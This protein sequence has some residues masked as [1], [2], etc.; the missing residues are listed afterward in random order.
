M[1]GGA[2][3]KY[4]DVY[5][6]IEE[7]GSAYIGVTRDV[8]GGVM[9]YD[10]LE[11]VLTDAEKAL[12]ARAKEYVLESKLEDGEA[13]FKQFL[14]RARVEGDTAKKLAYYFRRDTRGGYGKL[15]PIMRDPYV[16]DVHVNGRDGRV[17]IWHS[18]YENMR[19]NVALTEEEVRAS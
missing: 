7:G 3:A 6:P 17:F 13:A 14:A 9:R 12:L 10:V 16:E 1:S 5:P 19:T 8:D 11:P 18:R 15:D 2:G 4:M